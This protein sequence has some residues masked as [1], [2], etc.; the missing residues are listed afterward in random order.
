MLFKTFGIRNFASKKGN[1]DCKKLGVKKVAKKKKSDDCGK[2]PKYACKSIQKSCKGT[3]KK[4]KCKKPPEKSKCKKEEK[5]C[6]KQ[7]M[8]VVIPP[9]CAKA[10]SAKKDSCKKKEDPCKKKKDPCKKEKENPCKK[11]KDPCKKKKN[12]CSA[13]SA[14]DNLP[15]KPANKKPCRATC[16][17]KDDDCEDLCKRSKKCASTRFIMS[18]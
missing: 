3:K 10:K 9:T 5:P 17:K 4:N 14:C 8:T 13:S 2:L 7:M 16:S 15:C 11:K 12:D 1:A 18:A 6:D